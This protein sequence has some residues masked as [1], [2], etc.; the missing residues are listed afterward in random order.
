MRLTRAADLAEADD[1]ETASPK[2]HRRLVVA[3]TGLLWAAAAASWVL[4]YRRVDGQKTLGWDLLTTW[5]AEKVFAHGGEPYAVKAFVYPPS[6]LIVLRPLA[7]LTEHELTIGGLVA[8][9][10]IACVSVM[11]VAVAIGAR[12]WGPTAAATILLMSL[13]GAMRGEIGLENVSV[14]GFL[15]LAL[16]F[17]FALRDHWFAAAVAIGLSISIK[18]LLVVV[19]VV[20]LLARRWWPFVVAVAVPVVLNVLGI[21]LVASPHL[22][23]SK[24][25]SLLNR[26]GSGVTYN[27]AWVDVARELGMPEAATLMLRIATA[28]L[29][30][31]AAWFAWNR[32][33]DSRLRIITTTSV[34]LIGEFLVGTLSEYH[35]MLTLI[36]LAMT[37]VISGSAIRTV[38]GVVGIAWAM[39]A[40]APPPSVLGLERNAN[41]SAFRAIGMSLV[42]LTVT[43]VL[44]RRGPLR[45]V[46]SPAE[47]ARPPDRSMPSELVGAGPVGTSGRP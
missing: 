33:A 39:D 22:V 31:A 37:V 42:V 25:P 36:P 35:F 26:S 10:V 46:E 30:L 11:I 18:P 28:L 7:A 32:F 9:A 1:P 14:L 45:H 8:T 13:T 19:L 41:D 15:A 38:T 44:A 43:F 12:W 2:I 3:A 47:V 16:F 23:W 21:A 4:L 20:F 6:C 29:V 34:L 17:I 24:L 27:S 40:L 5:R